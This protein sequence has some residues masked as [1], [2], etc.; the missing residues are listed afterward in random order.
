MSKKCVLS[1]V[2]GANLLKRF[3]RRK[4]KWDFMQ[5]LFLVKISTNEQLCTFFEAVYEN[6]KNQVK[7]K[8][9]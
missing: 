1:G 4:C 3:H 5:S 2:D 6:D 8:F 7:I 9:K